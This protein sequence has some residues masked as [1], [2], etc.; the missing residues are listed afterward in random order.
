MERRNSYSKYIYTPTAASRIADAK[1]KRETRLLAQTSKGLSCETDG[2]L[3]TFFREKAKANDFLQKIHRRSPR[4]LTSQCNEHGRLILD[5]RIGFITGDETKNPMK[6][7]GGRRLRLDFSQTDETQKR[8]Q[9][10]LA[11]D[12]PGEKSRNEED[13]PENEFNGQNIE[14]G[15]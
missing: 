13:R 3:R 10:F 2:T 7:L 12:F 8:I 11:R 1:N 15:F 14:D 9:E 5:K 4:M 6:V